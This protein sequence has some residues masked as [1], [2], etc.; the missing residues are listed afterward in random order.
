[1]VTRHTAELTA[2]A[3]AEARDLLGTA[4]TDFTDL[5]WQHALGGQH[6]LVRVDG[7][8]VAHG[9]LVQRRLLVGGRS[10]RAG[11]VEG[12]AV[13]PDHRRQ[14][15]ASAVMADLERLAPAYDVLALSASEVGVA[16]YE[17]RGWQTWRGPTSVLG[18]QGPEP[19]PDDDGGVYVLGGSDLDLDAP[20]A[21]D[22]RDG[23][24]W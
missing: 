18:P 24:V 16:L 23:D 12:V 8:L 7:L 11:Y 4:F 5:D 20:I 6:A 17:A 9:S 15:H 21:C 13:H 19:T 14:G 22:W 10:L 3:L 2:A 1:M